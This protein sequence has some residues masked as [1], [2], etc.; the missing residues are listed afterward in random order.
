M[1]PVMHSWM[2]SPAPCWLGAGSDTRPRPSELVQAH[3]DDQDDA[4]HDE[5]PE[6]VD[7]RDD[8][9]VLE[10]RH[11]QHSKERPE[12]RAHA[13]REAGSPEGHPGDD[14]QLDPGP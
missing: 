13:A 5:L 2:V 12:D 3:A 4:D 6:G 11:E 7:P 10:Q 1:T 14:L 9:R 8:H